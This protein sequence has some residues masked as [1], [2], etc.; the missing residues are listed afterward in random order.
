MCTARLLPV[1]PSMHCSGVPAQGHVP[2]P[3]GVY[4][5]PEGCTWSGVPG[6]G[7]CAWS[8]GVP[9]LGAFTCPGKRGCTWS[10][11][12][13]YLPR[14][15]GGVPGPG[16]EY[17]LGVYLVTGGIWSLGGYL[18]PG[19]PAQ[20]ACIWSGGVPALVLPL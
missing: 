17:L 5:I 9:G 13:V 12:G 4:L 16:E 15:G 1:S 19:V 8:G 14:G 3:R 6:P 7:G 18:V 2:G 10:W 11:V 20:G